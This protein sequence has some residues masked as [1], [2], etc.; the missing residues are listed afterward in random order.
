M[1]RIGYPHR[2]VATDVVAGFI[3]AD[4]LLGP[5]G[6]PSVVHIFVVGIGLERGRSFD[7][8]LARLSSVSEIECLR[9]GIGGRHESEVV[10]AALCS[11]CKSGDLYVQPGGFGGAYFEDGCGKKP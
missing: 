1:T 2:V 10:S 7:I 6:F 8:I 3:I 9:G 11:V 4:V 5:V